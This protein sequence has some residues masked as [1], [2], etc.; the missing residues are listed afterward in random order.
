M[1]F[2]G[3]ALFTGLERGPLDNASRLISRVPLLLIFVA[4]A[5]TGVMVSISIARHPMSGIGFI[6]FRAV[7]GGLYISLFRVQDHDGVR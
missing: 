4:L 2:C 7:S 1:Y 6:V 3:Q 5:A